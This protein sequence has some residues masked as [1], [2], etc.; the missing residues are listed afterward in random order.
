MYFEPGPFQ[1][2]ATMAFTFKRKISISFIL[3]KSFDTNAYDVA[4]VAEYSNKQSLLCSGA[5]INELWVLTAA[6]C[7]RVVQD[8]SK[9][10]VKVERI[11][12]VAEENALSRK[13]D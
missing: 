13:S 2:F 8:Y 10:Q 11:S 7:S 12:V 4:I 9:D 1:K 5:I 3:N 6:H